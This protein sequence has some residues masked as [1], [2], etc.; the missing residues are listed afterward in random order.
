MKI[1]KKNKCHNAKQLKETE[2]CKLNELKLSVSS[3]TD[4]CRLRN[5]TSAVRM[6]D[7]LLLPRKL[8]TSMHH[9]LLILDHKITCRNRN[10]RDE[11]C[12]LCCYFLRFSC[13][14][15]CRVAQNKIDLG[16]ESRVPKLRLLIVVCRS[17]FLYSTAAFSFQG[18]QQNNYPD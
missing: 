9:Y 2:Q 1:I 3:H 10:R 14:H 6:A 5:L 11:D 17:S 12:I 4:S 13:K 18:F 8:L 15:V 16:V 7:N